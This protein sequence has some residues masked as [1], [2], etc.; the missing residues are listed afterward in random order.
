MLNPF[1]ELLTYSLLA[2]FILRLVVGFIFLD[3]GK[4]TL[5]NERG[6]WLTSFKTLRI[7]KP[8]IAVKIFGIVEIVC[9]VMLLVGVYTQIAALILAIFV[10]IEAYIEYKDESI[11]KRNFV[12][13]VTILAI[14]ISLLLSGAGAFAVD[15]PL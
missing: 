6:S 3:L 7:P 9:G 1:P 12:F 8:D 10:L 14:L 11:L 4:F 2:P 15:I 13:Y 5:Q